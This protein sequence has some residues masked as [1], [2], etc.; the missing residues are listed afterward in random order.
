MEK[1][2]LSYK[3]ARELNAI[4]DEHLPGRPSFQHEEIVIGGEAF[5][6]YFRDIIA[7]IRIL[8]GDPEFAPYIVLLPE[9]HYTDKEKTTRLYHDMHRGKWWWS[10]QAGLLY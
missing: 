6:V 9:R 8:Y 4:I 7:C 10:T 3:N 5:D 1:L 2:E